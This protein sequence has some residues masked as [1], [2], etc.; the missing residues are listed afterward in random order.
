MSKL[1]E[2]YLRL[3]RN[4]ENKIYLF[5]S[6]IFYVA[7]DEDAI[8]LNKNFGLKLSQFNSEIN[9]CGFPI[10]SLEKYKKLFDNND[11]VYEIVKDSDRESIIKI[12]EKVDID[13]ITPVEA[14]NILERMVSLL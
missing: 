4:D 7:L 14:F 12:L 2:K 5:K 11:F 8:I 10:K 6:G 13:N 1:Y 3:K 9:K